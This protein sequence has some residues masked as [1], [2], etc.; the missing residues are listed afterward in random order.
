MKSL[1]GVLALVVS[2]SAFAAET[3]P[4]MQCTARHGNVFLVPAQ[5]GPETDLF[6]CYTVQAEKALSVPSLG[7]IGVGEGARDVGALT[8]DAYNSDMQGQDVVSVWNENFNVVVSLPEGFLKS[9]PA[10]GTQVW[11]TFD[12]Y[13]LSVNEEQNT[14]TMSCTVTQ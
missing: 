12:V 7:R 10:V 5:C 13:Y 2:G 3:Y 4:A 8:Y 14:H 6:P 9:R 11:G 1:F